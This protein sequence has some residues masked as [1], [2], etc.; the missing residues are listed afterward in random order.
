MARTVAYR[1]K[2]RSSRGYPTGTAEHHPTKQ[3]ATKAR[4]ATRE[5]QNVLLGNPFRRETLPTLW[6]T[7]AQTVAILSHRPKLNFGRQGAI[8]KNRLHK[9]S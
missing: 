9:P 3:A 1:C 2:A 4:P 5:A 6:K 8:P 7:M